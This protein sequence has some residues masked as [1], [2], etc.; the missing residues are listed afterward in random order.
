MQGILYL[1]RAPK[2]A[3]EIPTA[4]ANTKA[5][6]K[7]IRILGSENDSLKNWRNPFLYIKKRERKRKMED[8][9]TESNT[10]GE[11]TSQIKGL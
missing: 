1:D 5:K 2:F 3:E 10:I 9:K 8:S 7:H 11:F 6:T 4:T